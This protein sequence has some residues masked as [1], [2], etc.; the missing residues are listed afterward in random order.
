MSHRSRITG[1]VQYC[2]SDRAHFL[3]LKFCKCEKCKA[4]RKRAFQNDDKARSEAPAY[5]FSVYADLVKFKRAN[6]PAPKGGIR[7]QIKGFSRAARKRLLETI[8]KIRRDDVTQFVT[9]TYPGEYSPDPLRWKRDLATFIKRLKRAQP[10]CAGIWRLEFQKRG[11]P[12][13]HIILYGTTTNAKRLRQWVSLAWYEIVGSGDIRHKNVGTRVD[14]IKS[15]RHAVN[16]AS[17]Y[18]AKI[19]DD[20]NPTGRQW[21]KFGL[22]ETQPVITG[23]GKVSVFIEAKRTVVKWLKSRGNKAFARRLAR[24]PSN[25]G[26]SV[27][28]LGDKS[29]PTWLSGIQSTIYAICL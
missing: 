21:G 9:L 23:Q 7:G 28:G 4:A 29:S 19:A 10:N 15:R 12:H 2:I 26:F 22:L 5:Y 24:Q 6:Q 8:A 3:A 13:F 1:L 16:Y 11:A 14:P 18:A 17:K 27:F 20:V 25:R